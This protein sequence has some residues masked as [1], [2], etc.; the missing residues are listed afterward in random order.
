LCVQRIFFYSE[1]FKNLTVISSVVFSKCHSFF[2]T[3]ADNPNREEKDTTDWCKNHL[4][5]RLLQSKV[6]ASGSDNSHLSCSITEVKDVT[7]DASVATVSGKK[8]YIFDL[9]CK[10]IFKIKDS[11]T[12]KVIASG[13]LKLPDL[14]STHHDE[15][16]V[17]I[18]CWKKKPSDDN[19]QLAND[20]RL[21]IVSEVR[22]SIKLWVQDFNNQY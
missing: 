19:Q 1:P 9:Q 11:T 2:S 21:R 12:D 6:E 4:E 8:R 18:D 17:D 16:E 7:G 14:C 22:E 13:S 5:K 3:W 15:L 20:C 10:V